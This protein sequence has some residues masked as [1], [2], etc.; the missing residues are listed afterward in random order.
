MLTLC[1]LNKRSRIILRFH[2]ILKWSLASFAC[3]RVH[4]NSEQFECMFTY[5]YS[6]PQFWSRDQWRH[7]AAPSQYTHRIYRLLSNTIQSI[8]YIQMHWCVNIFQMEEIT[9]GWIGS[10]CFAFKVQFQFTSTLLSLF[11]I[12]LTI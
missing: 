7:Y 4:L 6:I 11:H 3:V 2:C 1:L 8:L 12:V 9:Y 5:E 10:L